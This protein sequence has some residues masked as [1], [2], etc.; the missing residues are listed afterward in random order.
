MRQYLDLLAHVMR[1]GT[2]REQR[3]VLRSTGERPRVKGVFGYQM[4]FNLQDGFPLVTTKRVNFAAVA[5]ELCWFLRGDSNVQYLRDR[6]VPIWD[7]WADEQGELGPVYGATW[8]RWPT[9][10]GPLDQLAAVVGGIRA[11]IA[12]PHA[13]VARRLVVSAWNPADHWRDQTWRSPLA[14]HT[15]YQFHV[16]AGRLSCHLYQRSAD[17]FLGVPYNIAS[18]ALLASVL[19]QIVGLLPGDLVHSFGDAHIYQNHFGQVQEQLWRTPNRLS[20]LS[21]SDKVV[22]IDTIEPHHF[23]L[24]DYFPAGRLAGEVAV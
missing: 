20:R 18:Y 17:L 15:L 4:R 5:A 16:D 7:A 3:A 14:C 22:G 21:I 1:H 19:A 24:H 6:G 12:D 13:A 11:T 8:R 2:L 9:P 23:Q 10:D